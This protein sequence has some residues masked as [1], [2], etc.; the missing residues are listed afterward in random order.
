IASGLRLAADI[1]ERKPMDG[2]AFSDHDGQIGTAFLEAVEVCAHDHPSRS[3]FMY[4]DDVSR[5]IVAKPTFSEFLEVY[6][7]QNPKV[8]VEE[9]TL[10]RALKRLNI[11]LLPSK[12]GRPTGK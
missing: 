6:R 7:E 4:E 1:L 5:I 2:R 12:R 8:K 10:R 3:R 9:R 11:R